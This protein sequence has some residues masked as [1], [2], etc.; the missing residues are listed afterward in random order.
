MQTRAIVIVEDNEPIACLIQEVLNDVPGYGAVRVPDGAVALDVITAVRA[1]L[2]ILDIDLPGINGFE[3]YDRLQS[4]A[5]TAVIPVLFMSAAAHE[6]E[7]ARR[8][9]CDYL[10]KPFDLDDLLARVN[11]I[12]DRP[13]VQR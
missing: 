1:D 5:E 3:L 13:L 9:I 11:A 7:L 2:V 8:G 4:R 12:F 6:E 10:S